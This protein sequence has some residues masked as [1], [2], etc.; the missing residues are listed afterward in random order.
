M[1]IQLFDHADTDIVGGIYQVSRKDGADFSADDFTTAWQQ[2]LDVVKEADP[3][4]WD[5]EIV[6]QELLEQGWVISEPL[7]VVNV[8]Y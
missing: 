6:F 4:E 5:L 8:L 1:F 2:S 7:N 3:E